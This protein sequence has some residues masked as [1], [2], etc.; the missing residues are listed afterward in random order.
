MKRTLALVLAVAAA[1]IVVTAGSATATKQS[2]AL[3]V[4][5]ECSQYDG[6]A[7]SYCTITSSNVAAI[8]PGMK[9]VYLAA[10]ADG[11]LSSNIVL[12]SGQGGAAFGR[13]VL[14]LRSAMGFVSLSAGTG[15][16]AGFHAHVVVSLDSNGVWHWDGTYSFA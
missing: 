16:F 8:E 10:P 14:G 6:S 2:G 9:V 15:R 7:G 12:S 5:K 1:G 11:V 4:T 3:H 13:V